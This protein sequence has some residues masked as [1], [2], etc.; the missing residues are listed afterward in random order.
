MAVNELMS[1]LTLPT[2]LTPLSTRAIRVTHASLLD[3]AE[4]VLQTGLFGFCDLTHSFGRGER[5]KTRCRL[6]YLGYPHG[7]SGKVHLPQQRVVSLIAAQVH[8]QAPFPAETALV[9]ALRVGREQ[10]NEQAAFVDPILDLALPDIAAPQLG[11]VEPHLDAHG[12]QRRRDSLGRGSVLRGVT[13]K[14]GCRWLS[15]GRCRSI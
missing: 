10:G 12:A 2:A 6:G 4:R 1:R 13:E 5:L 9:A 11:F 14:Y 3:Y 8:R 7:D 15:R